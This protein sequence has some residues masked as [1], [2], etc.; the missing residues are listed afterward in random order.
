MKEVGENRMN[1]RNEVDHLSQIVAG[2]TSGNPQTNAPS[3]GHSSE[4]QVEA[5]T[6]DKTQLSAAANQM[7]QSANAS[8]VRLDKVTNI[9]SA[10]QAGTYDVSAS[11]VAQKLISSLLTSES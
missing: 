9:Q 2:Q 7:A 3:A 4:P 8:D 1:V 10:L 5:L 11:S 6:A